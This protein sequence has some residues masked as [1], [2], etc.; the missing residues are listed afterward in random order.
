MTPIEKSH[1]DPVYKGIFLQSKTGIC[2]VLT[3]G[4]S[5]IGRSA[6]CDEN[7]QKTTTAT[8]SITACNKG[9]PA[10]TTNSKTKNQ[11]DIYHETHGNILQLIN[12]G[13]FFEVCLTQTA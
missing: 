9:N 3:Y 11:S 7:R 4:S 13:Q 2:L 5:F 10:T 1:R 8:T 6:I 12:K